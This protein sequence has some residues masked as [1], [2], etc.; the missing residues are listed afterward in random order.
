MITHSGIKSFACEI[1]GTSFTKNSSLT[2]HTRLHTGER[3][4]SCEMCNMR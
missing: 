2:K 1:C 3:P 4:Y